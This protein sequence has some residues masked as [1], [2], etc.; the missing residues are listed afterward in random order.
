MASKH[1]ISSK[2]WLVLFAASILL[3][4][5]ALGAFNAV[6]DP[7]GVFGDRVFTWWSYDA[8]NNPR[9]A[10]FSY[11][12]QHHEEYDSYIIGCSSTSS[13]PTEQ[14][15][16]YFDAKFYNLIM[17]SA[18]MLDVEQW[19]R[20]LVEHYT[21]KHLVVNVYVDNGLAYDFGEGGLTSGMPCQVSGESPLAYYSRYLFADP[22]YGLDKL[23]KLRTDSAVQAVHDVFNEQTGAYD[24][25]VRDLEHISD[26]ESY[27]EAYPVFTDYKGP[28]GPLTRTEECMRSIAAIR[29]LCRE[30]GVDLVVVTAPLY[31]DCFTS[32]PAEDLAAFYQAL[33]EVVP[34]WDFSVSPV[35]REPR[36]FYDG[37]HFRNCV[38]AMALARM[39]GDES[40][41]VPEG[42]GTYVTADNAAEHIA[43]FWETPELDAGGYTARVP[44]L[45]YHSIDVEGVD[46]SKVT[47]ERFEE[48]LS[49]LEQAGY[50]AVDFDQLLAYVE[51]GEDLP[52]RPVVI[53]FDDGYRDNMAVVPILE[54]HGMKM[55][56]FAIGCSVGKDTYKDTGVAMT[57]HFT[58]EEAAQMIST[59]A[60]AIGSH[61]YDVHEV[62]GR[63]PSPVRLGIH[64]REEETEEEYIAFLREDCRRFNE[65]M[66]PVTGR[67]AYLMAYPYGAREILGEIVLHEEGIQVTLTTAVGTNT[68]IK[69]MP[70]SLWNM[71]RHS[72]GAAVSGE[73]LLEKIG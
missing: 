32:Y 26:L 19:C 42:F 17:Y 50:T 8:T 63:D 56:I 52:D 5:A 3:F 73:E 28:G 39:F 27:L 71:S 45:M 2:G 67:P 18:D 25:S 33:A 31:Y 62:E 15:N 29:D 20:Y 66:E 70:Q 13:F 9:T 36:Y 58:R 68:V 11:L 46:D 51:R 21:V 65:L 16:E 64:R 38:G 30:A 72:V 34:Y 41:Y 4:I 23:E 57:P 24:K 54:A 55:T 69:G 40:V 60:V 35:S 12:E 49:A 14:L 43:G 44:I 7:F 6:V 53:T 61:G 48:H 1:A 47:P 10:K 59:G 22:Q 37:T